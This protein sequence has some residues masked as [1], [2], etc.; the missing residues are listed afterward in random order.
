VSN[1]EQ[2]E[3]RFGTNSWDEGSDIGGNYWS[4][5]IAAGNPSK[6]WSR[7]IKGTAMDNYPFQSQNGWEL[8]GAALQSVPS[9]AGNI[10]PAANKTIGNES[11][12]E[13]IERSVA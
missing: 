9:A 2:A 8:S 1:S 7:A 5:H 12:N 11:L 10:P 6:G 3:D 4:D 13:S